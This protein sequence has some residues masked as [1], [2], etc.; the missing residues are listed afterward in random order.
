MRRWHGCCAERTW[1][2]RQDSQRVRATSGTHFAAR[3]E[4]RAGRQV[5][6]TVVESGRASGK[7]MAVLRSATSK[8]DT[9]DLST[10][11]RLGERIGCI[12]GDPL[13]QREEKQQKRRL[14]W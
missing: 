7:A 1:Q 10:A 14:S 3:E 13:K 12:G 11:R 4:L 9:R 8:D 2:R 6:R 5:R